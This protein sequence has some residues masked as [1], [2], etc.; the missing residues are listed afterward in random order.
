[1]QATTHP[2]A[3][4]TSI[5]ALRLP[6]VIKK[7]GLSRSHIYKLRSENLFPRGV[8]LTERVVVWRESE[9]D[10][11]LAD[12]FSKASLNSKTVDGARL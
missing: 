10:A 11:W 2:A 6:D 4:P 8:H 7:T 9:I 1:M 12:K 5:N 3:Q